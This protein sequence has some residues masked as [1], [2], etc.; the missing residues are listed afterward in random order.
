MIEII[1]H[2][3]IEAVKNLYNEDVDVSDVKIKLTPKKIEGD[4]TVIIQ[5]LLKYSKKSLIET[6][7]EIGDYL[8]NNVK[9]ICNY[10]LK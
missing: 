9:D 5:P 8:L 10:N 7:A 3:I 6:E 4:F 1:K 2:K